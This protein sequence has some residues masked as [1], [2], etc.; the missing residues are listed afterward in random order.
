MVVKLDID[1]PS[2]EVPLVQQ[3]SESPELL[4]LVDVFYFEHHVL[5][6][7]LAPAWGETM[8][9]SILASMELFSDLRK[10]GV[11]AHFW[12]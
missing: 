10:S 1:T 11:D 7:E 8:Q 9:G 4:K 5:L 3:L 12:V 6:S 2:V